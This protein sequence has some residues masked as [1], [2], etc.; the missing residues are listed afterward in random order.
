MRFN[1][2]SAVA[3]SLASIAVCVAYAVAVADVRGA[4]GF[5]GLLRFR[6]DGMAV[7]LYGLTLMATFLLVFVLC[8]G[9]WA[10]GGAQPQLTFVAN[11][12]VKAA[13]L[14]AVVFMFAFSDLSQFEGKSL[15][16]RAILYPLLAFLVPFLY[17]AKRLGRI[18]PGVFDLSLSFALTFD[19]VSNDLHYYGTWLHW[20]DF[21]H[22]F[23]SI[24]IMIVIAGPILALERRGRI[25]LGF[26]LAV[27][28]ALTIYISLHA[29]WEME[30]FLLDR[31]AGTNL[32]PG[33]MEEA[34]RNN[35]A[36][37]GG[38]LVGIGL[39]V[40]WKMKGTLDSGLVVPLTS[41][42]A[43][44]AADTAIGGPAA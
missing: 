13:L 21:V 5:G 40:W 31:F 23:N 27:V 14:L 7:T 4:T 9:V 30:E 38:A 6:E 33:G 29:L 24:P 28:F 25:A 18:Y 36:S 12:L 2:S 35:L 37:M 1:L 42:S 39:L 34:T 26:P 44:S 41:R 3:I 10:T 32:Q 22:F 19:I 15:T 17:F 43:A 8:C 16:Y 20:D 11:L